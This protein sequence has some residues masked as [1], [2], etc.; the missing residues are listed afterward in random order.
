MANVRAYAY[1]TSSVPDFGNTATIDGLTFSTN[2]KTLFISN[3]AIG[4]YI[5]NEV[6]YFEVTITH[7][8]ATTEHKY[9]PLYVGIHKEPTT[10]ILS[11]D[12]CICSVF[13]ETATQNYK[14][15]EKANW[16][17]LNKTTDIPLTSVRTRPPA[18]NYVIGL[19][20]DKPANTLTVY[21]NGKKLYSF[22]PT[23]FNINT[24]PALFYPVV[25]YPT[26]TPCSGVMNFGRYSM[27]YLPSGSNTCHYYENP[28]IS[29]PLIP[30]LHDH[31]SLITHNTI[32]IDGEVTSESCVDNNRTVYLKTECSFFIANKDIFYMDHNFD[33]IV[34]TNF[35]IPVER[36]IYLEFQVKNGTLSSKYL[37]IPVSFGLFDFPEFYLAANSTNI[38]IPLYH[39]KQGNY[40]YSYKS[41]AGTTHSVR[42]PNVL[43][44]IPNE[45]GKIIGVGISLM[46]KKITVW[47][48][49]VLFCQYDIPSNCIHSYMH[50]YIKNDKAFIDSVDGVVNFG[51]NEERTK[52][53][54]NVFKMDL[55]DGYIS[56][57]HYYNRLNCSIVDIPTINGVVYSELNIIKI[58]NN[59]ISGMVIV[60]T[61][62]APDSNV[63]G[64]N[65]LMYTYNK[66]HDVK[67]HND[68]Q[69][70]QSPVDVNNTI[71][72]K[73]RGWFP[74][75]DVYK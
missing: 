50:F 64:L 54:R 11:N 47:V 21:I 75:L 72:S 66:V 16:S 45:E 25:Y 26:N 5:K 8:T 36:N 70:Y 10:G 33:D 42:I 13:Y 29:V 63:H 73:Y 3:H 68:E 4:R 58:F 60:P 12:H 44:S 2:R 49:K 1:F 14:V 69:R 59:M 23:L 41:S 65:H 62:I 74:E 30:I 52:S 67:P 7:Y 56:L 48:D 19:L 27:E 55:P 18:K 24:D 32:S 15:I 39:I 43:T 51:Q 9:I 22:S 61:D 71:A 57:W 53:Q 34:Y 37:G 28:V 46:A 31:T 6:S 17:G 35:P 20:V 40:T 38:N